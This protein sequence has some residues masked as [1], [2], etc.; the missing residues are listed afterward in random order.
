MLLQA[1]TANKGITH[2]LKYKSVAENKAANQ[3]LLLNPKII[4]GLATRYMIVNKAVTPM[5]YD[6]TS[7][8]HTPQIKG[9]SAKDI[10]RFAAERASSHHQNMLLQLM[11]AAI[12]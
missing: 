7:D 9:V 5:A 2:V 1:E 3:S 12:R 10:Q 8:P 11:M 4:N 6:Y